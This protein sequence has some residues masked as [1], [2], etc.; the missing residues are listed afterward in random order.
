VKAQKQPKATAKKTPYWVPDYRPT[1]LEDR[2]RF[3]ASVLRGI[4]G[5]KL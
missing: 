3:E 4:G 1:S 2:Q 5:V